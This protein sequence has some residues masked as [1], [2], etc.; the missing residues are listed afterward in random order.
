MKLLQ[1]LLLLLTLIPVG[2]GSIAEECFY[3]RSD[4]AVVSVPSISLV[5]TAYRSVARCM[6]NPTGLV[7]PG[8][9]D[10]KG[11]V[12]SETMSSPLGV[13]T[14]RWPRAVETL[15]GRPP[16]RAVAE[17]MQA[18]SKGLRAT[19]FDPAVSGLNTSWDI[20]FMDEKLPSH[21]IPHDLV[22]NCHPGWMVPPG[23]IFIVAQR[24]AAGCGG[25]AT[26]TSV[27]DGK[28]AQVL[29]H[30]IGHAI[31]FA[32]LTKYP[33]GFDR[34]RAEGY[35]AEYSSLIARGSVVA[36]Y[37]GGARAAFAQAP[38]FGGSFGGEFFDYA[39]ASI[40]FRLVERRRG[41]RDIQRAYTVM[42]QEQ[43]GIVDAVSKVVG[44]DQRGLA[45]ESIKLVAR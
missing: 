13:V 8:E 4:G 1:R 5:P 43:V 34:M 39:K 42:N 11:N 35:A 28:L 45:A 17:A 24:V 29:I 44:L 16:N 2:G 19:G 10:L 3:Q 33:S 9:I 23:N 7:A 41:V 20:V 27:A 26:S 14:L 21:Q 18:A 31:E 37:A 22:S 36:E 40:L 32:L 30:E 15:F 6:S 12:R 25:K 38:A